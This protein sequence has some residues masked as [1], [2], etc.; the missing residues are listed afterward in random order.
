MTCRKGASNSISLKTVFSSLAITCMVL[1]ALPEARMDE[2]C[3]FST[4]AYA[5]I[6]KLS[7]YNSNRNVAVTVADVSQ[8]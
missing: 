5:Q 1:I 2:Y 8:L 4:S 6:V 7:L 3:W